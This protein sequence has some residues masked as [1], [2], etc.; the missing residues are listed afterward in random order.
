[1]RCQPQRRSFLIDAGASV[2]GYASDITRTYS[3]KDDGFA[4]LI[5]RFDRLQLDL[6]DEVSA[7]VD[8]TD[9]HVSCHRKIAD[10]LVEIGLA[11]GSQDTLIESGVTSAFYP[12]GLGHL[13]GRPGARHRRPYGR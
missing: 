5:D 12:H 10:L 13:L 2:N 3:A 4:A 6:V 7:G 9:L 1:M 11:R 8:F